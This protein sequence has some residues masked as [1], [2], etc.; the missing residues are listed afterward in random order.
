[1]LRFPRH[2]ML[3]SRA[4]PA[5]GRPRGP[6]ARLLLAL[7]AVLL[8]VVAA[9]LGTLIFVIALGLITIVATVMAIRVWW[10][11]RRIGR[12]RTNTAGR[13]SARQG[14]EILDGEF[15]VLDSSRDHRHR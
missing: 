2:S 12:N 7:L 8:F 9:V 10:W 14:G 11:R 1:M 13:R 3:F 15:R 5:S 4:G 6:I